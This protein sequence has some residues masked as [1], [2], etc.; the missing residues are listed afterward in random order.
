MNPHIPTNEAGILILP[1]IS[2][3]IEK[4]IHLDAII[5]TSPPD[6]PPQVLDVSKGFTASPQSLLFV[7]SDPATYEVF[8]RTIKIAP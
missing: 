4:G 6:E 5:P 3:Q 7:C 8:P 1:P 2:V